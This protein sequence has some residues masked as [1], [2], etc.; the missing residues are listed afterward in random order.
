[1]YRLARPRARWYQLRGLSLVGAECACPRCNSS[2]VITRGSDMPSAMDLPVRITRSQELTRNA[3]IDGGTPLQNVS[4][5][6]IYQLCTVNCQRCDH[7]GTS[8]SGCG[9]VY[10]KQRRWCVRGV[11]MLGVYKPMTRRAKIYRIFSQLLTFA[12]V[13][14]CL[15]KIGVFAKVCFF[16]LLPKE[17][18][19]K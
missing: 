8:H 13:L 4:N 7:S 1:M 15:L 16:N 19:L 10:S 6:S 5:H 3:N 11:K 18:H 12:L 17:K 2:F 14:V 9:V